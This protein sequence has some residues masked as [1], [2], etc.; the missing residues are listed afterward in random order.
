MNENNENL[1]DINEN[2]DTATGVNWEVYS[3]WPCT[4]DHDPIDLHRASLGSPSFLRYLYDW[5]N[6]PRKVPQPWNP[7]VAKR[8]KKRKK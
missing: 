2:E 4:T 8:Q 6:L 7:P 5:Y 3:H 1:K